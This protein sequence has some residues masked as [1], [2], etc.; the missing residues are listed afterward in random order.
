MPTT[1]K[2]LRK[3]SLVLVTATMLSLPSPARAATITITGEFTSFTSWV[4]D[5]P[6]RTQQVNGIP[7]VSTGVPVGPPEWGYFEGNVVTFGA[8]VTVLSFGYDPDSLNYSPPLTF[9]QNSVIYRGSGRRR[10]QCRRRVPDRRV[11]V[12]ERAV[13]LSD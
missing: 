3:C 9:L 10:C 4:L 1:Q 11:R 6:G 13:V 7:L 8:G 2:L 5:F 12:H